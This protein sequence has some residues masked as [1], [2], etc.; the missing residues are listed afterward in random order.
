MK[1]APVVY[2]IQPE[3]TPRYRGILHACLL[4]E[5]WSDEEFVRR[6]SAMSFR[7]RARFYAGEWENTLTLNGLTAINN[8]LGSQGNSANVPGFAQYFA[9]GVNPIGGVDPSDNSLAGEVFRKV[10]VLI[11]VIGNVTVISTKFLST[12]ANYTYTNA[13]LFGGPTCSATLGS[14]VM[15]THVPYN[16]TKQ[17]GQPL[18]NDYSIVRQ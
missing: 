9:V 11:Q 6:W 13:A 1:E 14:G 7:E 4:P 16:Y 15:N 5:D 3:R 12:E 10:P 18:G 17:A 2:I 8:F